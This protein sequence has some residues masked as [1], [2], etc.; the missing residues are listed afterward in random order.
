MLLSFLPIA[1]L[2]LHRATLPTAGQRPKIRRLRASQDTF[3]ANV[4]RQGKP[5]S[6]NGRVAIRLIV[7]RHSFDG[8]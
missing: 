6:K 3:K 1:S 7:G 8:I 2:L 5:T 4:T